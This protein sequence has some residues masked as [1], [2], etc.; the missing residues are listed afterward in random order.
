MVADEILQ[1]I[2]EQGLLL[3][4]SVMDIV[5]QFDDP[6]VA[7]NFLEQLSRASGQKMLTRTVLTRN[8]EIVKSLVAQLPGEQQTVMAKVFFNLG[9]QLEVRHEFSS[10]D[11]SSGKEK[12]KSGYHI[13]YADTRPE[14]KLEVVISQIILE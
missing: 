11:Q 1:A 5:Q 9:V 14:K 6:R 10:S 13:F 8:S 3:E 7:K 12:V 4:K 2:R